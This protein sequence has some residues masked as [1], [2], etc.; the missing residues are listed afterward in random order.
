MV[1][2]KYDA[3]LSTYSIFL[4]PKAREAFMT[5]FFLDYSHK[6]ISSRRFVK[7]ESNVVISRKKIVMILILILL[8]YYTLIGKVS[9]IPANDKVWFIT[10]RKSVVI[11]DFRSIPLLR[12]IAL[13]SIGPMVLIPNLNFNIPIIKELTALY[14]PQC[15][16]NKYC[17][18]ARTREE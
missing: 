10:H 1:M 15:D 4:G 9:L 7:T 8:D 17:Q 14:I 2:T 13:P 5:T 12:R 18:R 11:N 3:W 6:M 16:H